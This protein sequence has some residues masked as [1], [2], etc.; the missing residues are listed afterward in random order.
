MR[1]FGGERISRLM[2]RMNIE[3]DEPIEHVFITKAISNAQKKVEG[4]HFDMRKHVLEYDDVMEKQRSIIYQRRREILGD[5]VRNL[6]LEMSEDVVDQ[7]MDQY[8]QEKYTDQWDLQGFNR[9]FEAVFSELPEAQWELE[10]LKPEE[11][12]EQFYQWVKKLYQDKVD[13][14]QRVADLNFVPEGGNSEERKEILDRMLMDLERQVLL[15]VNDNLWKDHLLSMDHL[16]EG[17]GLVGYAQKKPLDEYRKQAF[18]LF[19]DLMDRISNEAVS[20]FYKLTLA[21]PVAE[22]IRPVQAEQQ[23]EFIHGEVPETEKKPRKAQPV[24]SQP[25][26]GRNDPCPCGSGKKFKK[27]HGRQQQIA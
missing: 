5:D 1:I 16:R 14:F 19:S 24:R 13:Y 20:T 6:L 2:E 9:A 15:K 7:L 22:P 3:E 10:G 18:A 23:M 25:T 26:A 11:H 27:C 21:N 17:I 12:H 4:Y 8:C